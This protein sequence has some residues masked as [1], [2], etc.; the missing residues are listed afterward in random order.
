MTAAPTEVSPQH[1]LYRFPSAP[2]S[3]RPPELRLRTVRHCGGPPGP[4]E[5]RRDA[6]REG[7]GLTS[8][9]PCSPTSA[10]PCRPLSAAA[11][12]CGVT[13]E[14]ECTRAEIP[15]SH[16]GGTAGL[17][18]PAD[19]TGGSPAAGGGAPGG[20]GAVAPPQPPPPPTL[21]SPRRDG[22]VVPT[23]CGDCQLCVQIPR[24]FQSPQQV[25]REQARPRAPASRSLTP[26]RT[27]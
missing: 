19:A 27:F 17:Q 25:S 24:T 5:A 12:H 20:A 22:G 7:R 15:L 23:C 3:P 10:P 4:G 8:Q 16:G 2:R 6:D 13:A 14:A 21:P 1:Q 18:A 26:W 11:Q 9:R